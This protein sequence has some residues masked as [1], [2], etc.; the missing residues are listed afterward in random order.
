MNRRTRTI[1]LTF[2]V[3]AFLGKPAP[4]QVVMQPTPNPTVTAEHES[5]YLSGAAISYAGSVYYPAGPRVHFT[6]NEMVR[7][8]VYLGIPLYSRTTIEPYSVVYLPVG[9]GLLQPYE[10]PR[11]GALA[12]TSGSLASS[13]PASSVNLNDAARSFEVQAAGPPS[14]TT[15]MV[16]VH[17]P[18][19]VGT[20][21]VVAP[22]PDRPA[23]TGGPATVARRPT[24]TVIGGK[25]QGS[26]SI[27]IEFEGARWYMAGAAESIDT[28]RLKRVGTYH[29]VPVWSRQ[30]TDDGII[31]VPVTQVGGSLAVPYSRKR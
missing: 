11:T 10:R 16:A 9:P 13:L 28:T 15:T 20:V 26:N 7:S 6:P 31:Y 27:F 8:G 23:A 1:L 5:W 4:A 3:T 18:Q 21:G 12:E 14:Q 19:P 17:V 22:E 2:A 25:P 30:A 24:H 29:G